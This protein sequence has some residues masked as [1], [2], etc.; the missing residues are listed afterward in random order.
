[1]SLIFSPLD[2]TGAEPSEARRFPD[3]PTEIG[4]A[5]GVALETDDDPDDAEDDDA[6]E[7]RRGATVGGT[8]DGVDFADVVEAARSLADTY[9]SAL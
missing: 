8:V 6:R 9:P 7:E 1:M 3:D 2:S 4:T 5:D